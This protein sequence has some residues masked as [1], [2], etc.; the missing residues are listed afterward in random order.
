MVNASWL[1]RPLIVLVLLAEGSPTAAIAAFESGLTKRQQAFEYSQVHMGMEVRMQL[2]ASSTGKAEAAARAAFARVAMLDQMMSD[3]RPDSELRRL[4]GNGNAWAIVSADLFDVIAR[5]IAI[6]R[7]TDGAFDPTVGPLV[8]LWREARTARQLPDP[9]A[10]ETARSR[11]GWRLLELDPSRRGIRL[12]QPAMRLD[13]GGIAKGYILQEALQTLRSHHVTSALIEAGGDIVV[14]DP[15]PGRAGWRIDTPGASHRFSEKALRLTNAALSTSGP[16]AQD[17]E[18]GGIRYSH[19][20]DPRTGL[21]LTNEITA[22]VIS[23]D[24]AT[25]D[26]L[27]T[28]LTVAGPQRWKAMLARFPGSIASIAR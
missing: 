25:A 15:P 4:E 2:H 20:I 27:S 26:A 8:A 13:L 1:L 10:L 23:R 22:R 6:A 19:V 18:I 5:A 11:V 16:S 3:Y 14:G 12:S 24:A 7:A 9:R 17:V 21:G 28:A